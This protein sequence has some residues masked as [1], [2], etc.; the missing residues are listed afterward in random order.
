MTNRERYQRT[1]ST[2][3]ASDDFLM[4]VTP[5]KRTGKVRKNRIVALC[6][7]IALIAALAT[8]AYAADVG[9]IQRTIQ[10]WIHGDQTDAVMVVEEDGSY[11]VTY[12]D[13]DGNVKEMGGGGVAMDGFG[14]ERPLT[15][16]EILEHLSDPEVDYKDDGTVWVYYQNQKL[17]ITDKFDDDGI[18][19]VQLKNGGETLY[20]TIKY[21]D[22]YAMSPHGY[23][24]P[25]SF[26]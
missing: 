4:E 25:S 3:H 11:K 14:N 9:G 10:L 17:E 12:A 2:L 22:G 26:N 15:E 20:L 18:C 5:M 13:E 19:Y 8:A 21:N 7:A 16:E 24:S 23:E 1:F 6:A